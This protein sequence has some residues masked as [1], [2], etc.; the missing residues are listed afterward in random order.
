MIHFL[1]S[2][3]TIIL[4]EVVIGRIGLRSIKGK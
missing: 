4:E 3:S 1:M 2:Q